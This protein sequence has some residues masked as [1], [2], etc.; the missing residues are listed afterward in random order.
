MADPRPA[1]W[2]SYR[3][4][5]LIYLKDPLAPATDLANPYKSE[6]ND[7]PEPRIYN[8]PDA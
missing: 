5:P 7:T 1:G 8:V 4:Y 2:P 3:P 6:P